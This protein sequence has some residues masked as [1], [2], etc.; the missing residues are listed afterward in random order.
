MEDAIRA[1]V[2]FLEVERGASRETIRAY[3]SDLRQF[4]TFVK[5]I[6]TSHAEPF[7]PRTVDSLLIRS[8][9]ARL[10]QDKE[11]KS[12][13]ARKLA[14]LRSF[15][16]FL[17][18]EGR[19]AANPADDVRTPKLPQH[20]PRVLTKDDANALM[21]FPDGERLSDLRDRAILETL[22][23]TGTRVS[24]LVGMSWEDINFNDGIVRVTGKG[25]KERLVP[26]GAVA[27]E[28]IKEYRSAFHTITAVH[29]AL[30]QETTAVFRNSRG[31][32]LTARSVE[33]LVATY[34]S[35]LSAGRISPHALRHS[36]ATHLLDE[37][38]DLRAIQELLG[39]ASLDTTQKYTHLAMDQLL[40]VYDHAHPRAK[41]ESI[42]K[43]PKH[44]VSS[45]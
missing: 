29:L 23:S 31:G 35:R 25:R 42:K 8:Y 12:T 7:T 13:L 33:R 16:R 37:G 36:F 14:S 11:K 22:Y 4:V 17:M 15:Y 41:E 30:A 39:H 1:F 43:A 44:G 18:R 5:A 2:T 27:L 20:L 21:E 38:A 9:L 3:H 45:T 24:E 6:R 19:V 26:I 10:D 32:R 28:A 40:K 34:S